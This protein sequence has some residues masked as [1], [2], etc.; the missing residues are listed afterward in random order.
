MSDGANRTVECDAHELIRLVK[1]G[2]IQALDNMTRCHGERL[3]AVGR[4]ACRDS[5]RAEDAVQDALIS[6]GTNLKQ[7]SGKGSLEGWLVRMVQ[8]ACHRMRRGRK[9]DPSLHVSDGSEPAGLVDSPEELAERGQAAKALG[10]AL[11]SLS[12]EDRAILLLAD[13]KDWT[14]P[15]IAAELG[16][17]PA[18][19][20]TRL[21]RA[22]QKMRTSLSALQL[23]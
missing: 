18:T 11:E 20:R 21:S 14:G 8:N 15:E 17:N 10:E 22:R 12:P 1:A 9:N 6:A 5:D 19:V 4:K 2:D 7:W 23:R 16:M 13:A 3:L